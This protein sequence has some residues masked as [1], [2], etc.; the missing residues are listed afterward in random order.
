MANIQVNQFPEK[1]SPADADVVH[2]KADG[3]NGDYKTSI[4]S[5]KT[6]IV[7]NQIASAGEA[8]TGTSDTKLMT[9]SKT[10]TFLAARLA[11]EAEA[12][13]G[14]SSTKLM[15][16]LRVDD[17][18]KAN[19]PYLLSQYP[20]TS[21]GGSLVKGNGYHIVD[22]GSYTL[23]DVTGFTGGEVVKLTKSVLSEP[24]IARE[25]TNSEQIRINGVT[26]DTSIIFDINSEIALIYNVS[27]NEWEV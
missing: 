27:T 14:A 10:S 19:A 15:T 13:A 25:G 26:L 23:P 18:S 11:N 9:P 3:D 4:G 22:A 20:S 16:P 8:T 24:T 2:L 7:S 6:T 1:A 17:Y 21:G 12:Q 5:L